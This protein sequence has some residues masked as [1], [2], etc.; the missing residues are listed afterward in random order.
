LRLDAPYLTEHRI[1]G[2]AVVP[3]ASIIVAVLE[4]ARAHLSGS[5]EVRDIRFESVLRVEEAARGVRLA[6]R[7]CG[8]GALAFE[9]ISAQA[10]RDTPVRYTSGI[11]T[12]RE[13]P[14][15]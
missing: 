7:V 9:L 4:A 3:G 11:V 12:A 13:G 14:P 15:C 6:F 2:E 5:I 1:V 8:P 10:G